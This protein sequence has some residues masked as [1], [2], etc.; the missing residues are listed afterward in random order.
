MQDGVGKFSPRWGGPNYPSQAQCAL[1]WLKII[2][3]LHH[4]SLGQQ[5]QL[6][7]SSHLGSVPR[8]FQRPCALCIIH[9]CALSIVVQII[10]TCA[11]CTLYTAGMVH[12]KPSI[13]P[14]VHITLACARKAK[15]GDTVIT[16]GHTFMSHL[17]ARIINMKSHILHQNGAMSLH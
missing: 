8:S 10:H 7:K 4:F 2:L 16:W 5:E 1:V 6:S 17:E 11:F 15:D 9:S 12:I 3:H 14:A 13:I